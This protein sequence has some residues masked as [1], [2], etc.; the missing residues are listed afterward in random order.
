MTPTLHQ[1]FSTPHMF[2]PHPSPF[3]LFTHTPHLHCPTMAPSSKQFPFQ[4]L[5]REIRDKIYKNLLCSFGDP[6]IAP[7]AFFTTASRTVFAPDQS[8]PPVMKSHVDTAILRTN[9]DIHREAYSTMTKTNRFV[10]LQSKG[11]IPLHG[12]ITSAQV[13]VISNCE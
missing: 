11:S 4:R 2:S 10:L 6:P 13:S 3:V 5:Q 12:V 9:S 7:P 1:A 8:K